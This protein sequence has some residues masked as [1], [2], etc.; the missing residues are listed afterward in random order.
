MKQ[1]LHSPAFYVGAMGSR[2]THE[3]RLQYL[4]DIGVPAEKSDR[5]V[6]PIGLIPSTRDPATLALST[7]A[8]VVES[9]HRHFGF[10]T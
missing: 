4:A 1:A 8:Q 9:Y 5:M 6:A 3:L 7:L 2:K 10:K